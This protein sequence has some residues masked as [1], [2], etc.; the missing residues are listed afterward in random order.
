[1]N[2]PST[3]RWAVLASVCVGLFGA[4]FAIASLFTPLPANAEGTCG[5]GTGSETAAE[6]LF[7]PGSIGAGTKPPATDTTALEEWSA[8][9]DACQTATDDRALVAFP[10]LIVSIGIGAVVPLVV[11]RN[12]RRRAG[13]GS[14]PGNTAAGSS[15]PWP[16]PIDHRTP[17]AA[18]GWG[19]GA[20][21]I[22]PVGL[23][24]PEG[25]TRPDT[26]QGGP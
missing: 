4:A 13:P 24:P 7:E 15:P 2:L 17:R 22:T 3:A 20:P 9:V 26:G 16:A 23:G 10:V 12:A 18:T 21:E 14:G 8:F 6:A 25:G 5:P 11:L 1:M 19:S